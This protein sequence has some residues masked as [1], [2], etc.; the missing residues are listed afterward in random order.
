MVAQKAAPIFRVAFW[1]ELITIIG[2][3]RETID[4]IKFIYRLWKGTP[5]EE[6]ARQIAKIRGAIKHANETGDTSQEEDLIR[7]GRERF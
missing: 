6:R 1:T 2:F 4:I 7:R 5:A 3:L